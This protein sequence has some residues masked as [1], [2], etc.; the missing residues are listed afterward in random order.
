METVFR[1]FMYI[2]PFAVSL[3]L[4]VWMA[5]KASRVPGKVHK[6]I[7]LV[8]VGAGSLYTLYRIAVTIGTIFKNDKFNFQIFITTIIVLFFAAIAMAFGEPEK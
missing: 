3:A 6:T 7:A 5:R 4:Y 8:I 2:F 1:V